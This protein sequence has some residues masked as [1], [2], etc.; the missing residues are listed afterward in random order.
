MHT[1][2][3][4]SRISPSE[5]LGGDAGDDGDVGRARNVSFSA[6]FLSVKNER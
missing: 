5:G 3:E 2:M 1:S 6:M 4:A